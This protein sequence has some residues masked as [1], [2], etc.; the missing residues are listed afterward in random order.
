MLSFEL[1]QSVSRD[2]RTLHPTP[3]GVVVVMMAQWWQLEL[4]HT[5]PLD[6]RVDKVLAHVLHYLTSFNAHGTLA[7]ATGEIPSTE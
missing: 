7:D 5:S 3:V 4:T 6:L 2:Y 1:R